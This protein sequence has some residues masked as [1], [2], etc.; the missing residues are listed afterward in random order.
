M[1]NISAPHPSSF[2]LHGRPRFHAAGAQIA[3]K[4]VGELFSAES[5]RQP[6]TAAEARPDRGPYQPVSTEN[7][8]PAIS[9]SGGNTGARMTEKDP[10]KA[11]RHGWVLFHDISYSAYESGQGQKRMITDCRL[12]PGPCRASACGPRPPAP[13]GCRACPSCSRDRWKGRPGAGTCPRPRYIWAQ[14]ARS[15]PS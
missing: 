14:G 15:G 9:S 6:R 11:F 8:L 12:F 7:C 10:A 5:G 2:S 1:L 4:T 3:R 13:S